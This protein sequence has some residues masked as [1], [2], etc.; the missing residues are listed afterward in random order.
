MSNRAE[1]IL[2]DHTKLIDG[3]EELTKHRYYLPFQTFCGICDRLF[4]LSPRVQ[5]YMLEVR[6]IPVKM[7][8]RGA[9]YCVK[10]RRRRSRINYLKSGDKWRAAPG[11]KEEMNDLIREERN[12]KRIARISG[13]VAAGEA[14]A[15]L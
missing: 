13:G 4:E 10:C 8:Q 9:V 15:G 1:E 12:L 7:L 2:I 11:G 6:G 3:F 14:A 5:K